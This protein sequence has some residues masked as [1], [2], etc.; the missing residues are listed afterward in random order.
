MKFQKIIFALITIFI[1][2]FISI[3]SYAISPAISTNSHSGK[4]L[5]HSANDQLGVAQMRIFVNM[6][7]E[8]FSKIRGRKLNFFERLS[9][10]QAS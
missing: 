6:T 8:D 4:G 9:F 1:L 2:Y 5:R 7:V 10:R 3:F